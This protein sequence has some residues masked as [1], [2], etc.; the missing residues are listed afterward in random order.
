MLHAPKPHAGRLDG[1]GWLG[2]RPAE[3]AILER[4]KRRPPGT[5]LERLEGDAYLPEPALAMFSAH[6]AFLG[7]PAHERL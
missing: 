7:W 5:V 1:A 3:A 2:L 6:S 4:L